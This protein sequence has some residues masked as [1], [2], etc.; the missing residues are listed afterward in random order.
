M[1]KCCPYI[2]QEHWSNAPRHPTFSGLEP[3]TL[4]RLKSVLSCFK[5]LHPAAASLSKMLRM[6]LLSLC[7][8]TSFYFDI[9]SPRAH[10]LTWMAA[11]LWHYKQTKSK[12]NPAIAMA[13]PAIW[14]ID[15]GCCV[16]VGSSLGL[17]ILCPK[18]GHFEATLSGRWPYQVANARYLQSG[19]NWHASKRSGSVSVRT[20][21]W[22]C[23]EWWV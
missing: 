8:S 1:Q 5:S 20:S 16:W 23:F 2:T 7:K 12:A 14:N 18:P 22:D 3:K 15:F 13:N 19:A 6:L 9:I 17:G 21:F 10:C 4:L 11:F